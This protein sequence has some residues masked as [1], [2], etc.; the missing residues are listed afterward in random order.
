MFAGDER[1][2]IV[3]QLTL[4]SFRADDIHAVNPRAAREIAPFVNGLY[5]NGDVLASRATYQAGVRTAHG[6][7]ALACGLGTMPYH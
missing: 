4:E 2:V 7:G 1:D 5:E 6:L 3:W